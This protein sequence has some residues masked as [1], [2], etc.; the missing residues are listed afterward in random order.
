MTLSRNFQSAND[1]D[2]TTSI[3]SDAYKADGNKPNLSNLNRYFYIYDGV[4]I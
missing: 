4:F 1:D 2:L 3:N